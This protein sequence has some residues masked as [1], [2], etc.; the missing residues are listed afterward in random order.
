MTNKEEH[1]INGLITAMLE[2][3]F[4]TKH[5]MAQALNLSEEEI[6]QSN[7][8]T[9]LDCLLHYCVSNTIP[10]EPFLTNQ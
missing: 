4:H 8:L 5:A 3:H 10:L 2:T 9:V 6:D 7:S 1:L